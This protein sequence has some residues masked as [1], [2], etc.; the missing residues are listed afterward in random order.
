MNQEQLIELLHTLWSIYYEHKDAMNDHDW[1]EPLSTLYETQNDLKKLLRAYKKDY[2][3]IRDT[4]RPSTEEEQA[5]LRYLNSND[6][7]SD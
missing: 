6:S 7:I 4:Y 5:F 3:Y 2:D 1:H